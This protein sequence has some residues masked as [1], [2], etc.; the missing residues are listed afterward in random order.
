M[1]LFPTSCKRYLPRKVAIQ[2][3]FCKTQ[4]KMERNQRSYQKR[5]SAKDLFTVLQ[6]STDDFWVR[7]MEGKQQHYNPKQNRCLTLSGVLLRIPSLT[8]VEVRNFA[9]LHFPKWFCLVHWQLVMSLQHVKMS[10]LCK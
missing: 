2:V 1:S 8:K 10:V 6:L 4:F 9:L 5:I 3:C 7:T